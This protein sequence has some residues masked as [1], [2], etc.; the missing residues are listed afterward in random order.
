ME[1]DQHNQIGFSIAKAAF[2]KSKCIV[3]SDRASE[4]L[5]IP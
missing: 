5:Y 4:S 3:F 2:Y 1:D